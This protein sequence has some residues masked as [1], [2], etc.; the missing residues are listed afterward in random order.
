MRRDGER[1][2]PELAPAEDPRQGLAGGSPGGDLPNPRCCRSERLAGIDDQRDGRE[3]RGGAKADAGLARRVF[4][5]ASPER[6]RE[7]R[8]RFGTRGRRLE[9]EAQVKPSGRGSACIS[10][11]TR[12]GTVSFRP[13]RPQLAGLLAS[14]SATATSEGA[15]EKACF[16]GRRK[17]TER[18]FVLAGRRIHVLELHRRRLGIRRLEPHLDRASFAR[19]RSRATLDELPEQ[20]ERLGLVFVRA[21]R[22]GPCRASRSPDAGGRA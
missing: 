5:A 6:L 15:V 10:C 16:R 14:R 20:L 18:M 1:K 4:N 11:R 17:G 7:E 2:P 19:S 22:A 3:V 9:R 21:D 12:K 13:T 8:E